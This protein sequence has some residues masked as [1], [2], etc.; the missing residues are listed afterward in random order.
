MYKR[1]IYTPLNKK[2]ETLTSESIDIE[3]NERK[4]IS[5]A[6]KP[7]LS[8]G[9]YLARASLIYDG[10]NAVDERVF[11]IGERK[12]SIEK[13][14]VKNFK[15]G[16]IAK[17]EI[18]VSNEWNEKIRNVYAEYSISD[19]SGKLY[20]E[21]KTASI[22][23][24]A[25]GKGVLE[26]YWDTEKVKPGTYKLDIRLHFLNTMTRRIFNILVNQDSIDV[27]P[28]SGR[29]TGKS[30]TSISG[31]LKIVVY[32]LIALIIFNLFLYMKLRKL[33]TK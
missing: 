27:G 8:N 13:I 7:E 32:I 1:Q 33:K 14:G 16:G 5:I 2:I 26:A 6:W 10:K 15:L 23:L 20:V 25:N 17:F 28:F 9:K 18:I 22:D 24:P 19:T 11:T 3:P 30:D 29:V 31:L 21:E 12:I 4:L